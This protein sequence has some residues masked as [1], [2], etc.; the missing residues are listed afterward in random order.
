MAPNKTI[1]FT[2]YNIDVNRQYGVSWKLNEADFTYIAS[3]KPNFIFDEEKYDGY[4]VLYTL[5]PNVTSNPNVVSD[6]FTGRHRDMLQNELAKVGLRWTLSW[7]SGSAHTISFVEDL[8]EEAKVTIPNTTP[9]VPTEPKVQEIKFNHHT[10]KKK[11]SIYVLYN[12]WSVS[13]EDNNILIKCGTKLEYIKTP[14]NMP[15]KVCFVSD[16]RKDNTSIDDLQKILANTLKQSGLTAK[17]REWEIRAHGEIILYL[18]ITDEK[19]QM[20]ANLKSYI[21]VQDNK[22]SQ[23]FKEH[24]QKFEE[25]DS[26]IK[27]LQKVNKDLEEEKNKL[28]L[29]FLTCLSESEKKDSK[30]EELVEFHKKTIDALLK[31]QQVSTDLMKATNYLKQQIQVQTDNSVKECSALEDKCRALEVLITVKERE[32]KDLT[33]K[34]N[35]EVYRV[36]TLKDHTIS[37]LEKQKQTYDEVAKQIDIKRTGER[38]QLIDEKNALIRENEARGFEIYLKAK[39]IDVLATEKKTNEEIIKE[40]NNKIDQFAIQIVTLSNDVKEQQVQLDAKQTTISDKSRLLFEAGEEL[41]KLRQ[42]L[43]E[44]RKEEATWDLVGENDHKDDVT[45]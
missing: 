16:V 26:K 22:Y 3:L 9:I 39:S 33:Q 31:E 29:E 34:M 25:M 44:R 11:N 38:M 42:E 27:Q 45:S 24:N 15:N 18:D 13:N 30:I 2:P 36:I 5:H 6:K 1:F 21:E 19:D 35:D 40:L 28:G 4:C 7:E 10:M 14:D 17:I 37:Q 23:R 20:I 41:T 32:I 43:D 8:K 12:G